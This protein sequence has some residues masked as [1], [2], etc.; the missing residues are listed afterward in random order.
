MPIEMIDSDV[1]RK[2]EE[3]RASVKSLWERNRDL[4]E[5]Y[6]Q[7]VGTIDTLLRY[8]RLVPVSGSVENMHVYNFVKQ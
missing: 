6:R 2:E 5:K 3:L 1:R 7:L 8:L 4:E